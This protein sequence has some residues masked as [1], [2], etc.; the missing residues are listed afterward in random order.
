RSRPAA[1]PGEIEWAQAD[2]GTG[3][4]VR[5]AA[6]G[7]GTIA[8]SATNFLP[9]S[10]VDVAGT[11]RLLEAARAESA[12]HVLYIST[13]GVDANPFAYYRS[14]LKAEELVAE[15]GVPW[16]IQRAV[17]FYPFI[18]VLLRVFVHWPVALLPT[19]YQ[20]QPMDIR[21]AAERLAESVAAGPAE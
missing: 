19:D 7:G 18:D 4:G 12:P 13:V 11:G 10:K 17:Q 3:A 5:E 8:H 6:V 21:D 2:L 9:T 20:L 14:K 16:S 15:S 1:L